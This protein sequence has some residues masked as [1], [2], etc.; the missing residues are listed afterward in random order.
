MKK[1]WLVVIGMVLLL[2]VVGLVGCTSEGTLSNGGNLNVAL[3]SQQQGIW[4]NG[5]G[6]VT[7]VPDVAILT[8]GIESQETAVADAQVKASEAMDK[9]LQAL[10]A[11]GIARKDIQTQYFN[12]SQVTNWDNNKETVTGY[13][14]TN[15]VT[16]KERDV[17]KAGVVIDAVVAAG[18][19]MTRVNGIIFTVDEPADYYVQARE[20]AMTHAT[21]KA[22]ELANKTGIKL[23]KVTYITESSINYGPV[24][25][26]YMM[27]DYAMA[28]PAITVATPV[29]IG[30]LE[31]TATVQIAY[32]ID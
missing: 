1:I 26:N 9:V 2:G 15:T 4:V 22:Q 23:G 5:E 12:I 31:I 14:V 8:L 19:D 29:S 13:R 10:T 28:V 27:S 21:A 17:K 11:Q 16:V 6:K 25:P 7:V 3:N 20:L 32:A 30:Q 18:G 24:Y